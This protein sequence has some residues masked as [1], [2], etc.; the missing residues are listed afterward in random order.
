MCVIFI[1]SIYCSLSPLSP[2]HPLG[3][4]QNET[5]EQQPLH[6]LA[7]PFS[8]SLWTELSNVAVTTVELGDIDHDEQQKQSREAVAV[9]EEVVVVSEL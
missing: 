9:N 2:P 7:D 5:V 6:T 3:T 4:Y 1:I 8:G